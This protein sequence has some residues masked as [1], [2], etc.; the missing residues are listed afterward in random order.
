MLEN[1]NQGSVRLLSRRTLKNNRSRN[2]FAVLAIILTT[3]MFT[4]VFSIGFSFAGNMQIMLLRLQGTKSTIFLDHPLKKQI[5]TVKKA[6]DLEAAG[7]RVHVDQMSTKEEKVISLDYYDQTEFE[8]NY[9]PAVSGVKGNYPVKEQEIMLASSALEELGI[10]SPKIGMEV[11]LQLAGGEEQFRL[12]GWFKDYESFSSGCQAFVSEK[13]AIKQGLTVQKDGRLSISAKDGRQ[14]ELYEELEASVTLDSGQEWDVTFAVQDGDSSR[15]SIF[16]FVG[17]LALMIVFSGYLIIY[18]VMYISVTKDIRFYGLLK[19]IGTTPRQL[20]QIVRR[21]GLQLSL[22]GIPVG[23]AL[24]AAVSFLAVPMALNMFTANTDGVLPTNVVFQPL[25]YV[26]TVV[27]ALA[28]I[29]LSCRKPAR[30]A[31]RIVPVEAMK[32]HGISKLDKQLRRPKRSRSRSKGHKSAEAQSSE[33]QAAELYSADFR[34]GGGTYRMAWRNVFR[35]KKRAILVFA[36]LF[37]GTMA[38]LSVHTY[39]GSV[40]LENYVDSYLN[41]D[42]TIFTSTALE[43]GRNGVDVDKA[44]DAEKLAEKLSKI[45]GVS[46]V[47]VNRK[48]EVELEF[49]RETYGPF[50]DSAMQMA[51]KSEVE[52][53]IGL[54]ESGEM[55]VTAVVLGMDEA[56]LKEYL[57]HTGQK[58]DVERFQNGE[59]CLVGFLSEEDAQAM[60]GRTISFVNQ[61]NGNGA[62]VEVAAVVSDASRLS[63]GHY[64]QSLCSPSFIF[65]SNT[66]L[67]KLADRPVVD[68]I[69]MDC[70]PEAE[71]F[72]TQQVKELTQNH[73]AV[74][75]VLIKSEQTEY[76]QTA[77]TSMTVLASG[78]S[79]VLILI[80]ILNFVNVMLTGVY[81]RRKELAVLES[82]GMT[83]S[84]VR[85]MLMFEGVYYGSITLGL[86]LTLGN[87][88]LALV[89]YMSKETVDYAVFYYPWQYLLLLGA[90][91]FLIC[92][93]VPGLVYYFIAKESVTER[94]RNEN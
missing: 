92:M 88:L 90:G 14:L 45:E 50:I 19:S 78:I 53:A 85:K 80:G 47:Y 32:Y 72:V 56:M 71:R 20:G 17:L 9:L 26:G 89:A 31:S 74:D 12:S 51:G 68:S 28:T 66:L 3:F 15:T 41:Y 75:S 76:F 29:L 65:V 42:Y 54:Y 46:S 49:D 33:Q 87:V 8:Q 34:H 91:M 94:L 30:L 69:T 36:S 6:K 63:V 55:D 22:V 1:R 58:V 93:F 37:M 35:E 52:Q 27:F 67:E 62:S 83:R 73:A 82:V 18:N 81:T 13:Y 38:F 84:Q 5:D 39:M 25:I 48:I 4:T 7:I 40:K 60:L 24:G 23:I 59:L 21:Q 16:L 64:W 61:E 79:I 70:R 11:S 43:N 57:A 44:E 2:L 77:M 86:V 10:Q